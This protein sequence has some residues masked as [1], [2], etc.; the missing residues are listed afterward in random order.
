MGAQGRENYAG[1]SAQE[2]AQR[3]RNLA[4]KVED[5]APQSEHPEEKVEEGIK[6]LLFKERAQPSQ[7]RA[8]KR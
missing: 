6:A 3:E 7:A 5:T 8:E 4:A 2:R 1:V